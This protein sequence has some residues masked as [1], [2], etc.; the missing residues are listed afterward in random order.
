MFANAFR[1]SRLALAA[2]AGNFRP[3]MS[4]PADQLQKWLF[5]DFKRRPATRLFQTFV[6]ASLDFIR[7]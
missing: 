5:F 2:V 1:S 3:E 7:R 6:L 4:D